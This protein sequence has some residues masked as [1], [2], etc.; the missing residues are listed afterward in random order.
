MCSCVGGDDNSGK[1]S[2]FGSVFVFRKWQ[3]HV[4]EGWVWVTEFITVSIVCVCVCVCVS[5]S[6]QSGVAW[7]C[8][9]LL[10]QGP[11]QCFSTQQYDSWLVWS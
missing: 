6:G 5:V 2:F 10:V 3:Y 4:A 7:S 9:C 1:P 8:H 11:L